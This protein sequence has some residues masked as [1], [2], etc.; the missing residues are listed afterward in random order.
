[1]IRGG[2]PQYKERSGTESL[3]SS[4]GRSGFTHGKDVENEEIQPFLVAA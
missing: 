2:G 1:M 3:E 4:P